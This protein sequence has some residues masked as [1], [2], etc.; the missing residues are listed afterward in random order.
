VVLPEYVTRTVW[1]EVP[2]KAESLPTF[3]EI[4]NN[5]EGRRA[6]ERI[7]LAN[8]LSLVLPYECYESRLR[9]ILTDPDIIGREVVCIGGSS[10]AVEP[11]R[12]ILSG[13]SD[14]FPAS[15]VIVLHVASGS[16]GVFS[17]IASASR[18]RVHRAEDGM[19]LRPGNVYIAPPDH[20]LLALA[21]RLRLGDGPR[22]NCARPAIDPLFRSAAVSFGP[23]IIAVVLSGMLS[24]GAAGLAAVKRCGGIALVQAPRDALAPDMPLAALEATPVDLSATAADLVPAID[25][26]ARE[27]PGP[28]L[29]VPDDIRLEV[30]IAAGNRLGSERL[31]EMAA[32]V[33]ITCPDCGGVLSE[34]ANGAPLRFRCQV[35][36]AYNAD[37]LLAQQEG[38]VDEAVRVALRIIEERAEL[39]TRMCRDAARV[40]RKRLAETYAERAE[41]YRGYADILRKAAIE[42]I[43]PELTTR[44][45]SDLHGE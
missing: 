39:L 19:L 21:G 45:A 18:M 14:D 37:A 40:G 33:A 16:R 24:D 23:R 3:V 1:I 12:T 8:C 32:P 6:A 27:I 25:R 41:E 22:E 42:R 17:A 15:I 2:S 5:Q 34:M 35:G 31:R 44:H 13:L 38:Q 4:S 29:A 28:S 7:A 30:E 26:F 36:H 10:G 9:R 20:H 11:L 43:R